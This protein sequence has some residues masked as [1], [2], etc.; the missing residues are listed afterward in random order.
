MTTKTDYDSAIRE[1]APDLE[2][3]AVFVPQSKSRNAGDKNPTLN[4]R[5]TF[6]CSGREL[7]ADYMAGI[8]HLPGYKYPSRCAA[9]RDYLAW[10]AERGRHA[11]SARDADTRGFGHPI[12]APPMADVLHCLL[13]DA[14][15]IDAGSFQEWAD[16]CGCDTDSRKAEAMYRECVDYG[17]KLRAML[18]DELIGKLREALQDL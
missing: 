8:G 16:N 18:G 9:E 1:I 17:L 3:R 13:M 15:A 10:A 2:Y 5:V 12:P 4:W 14:E 7:T 11:L 6:S